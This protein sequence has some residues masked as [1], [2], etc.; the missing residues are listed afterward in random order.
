MILKSVTGVA[1]SEGIH[2]FNLGGSPVLQALLGG[3]HVLHQFV[4]PV[5]PTPGRYGATMKLFTIIGASA[6]VVAVLSAFL[7]CSGEACRGITN[8]LRFLQAS[9]D[10]AGV[11]YQYQDLL[12]D[13]RFVKI[14]TYGVSGFIDGR[15]ECSNYKRAARSLS[16]ADNNTNN[17]QAWENKI[18]AIMIYQEARRHGCNIDH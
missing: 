2:R 9:K 5:S 10:V 16:M 11:R 8:N 1:F 7:L 4:L 18:E 12:S 15:E 3:R 17:G 6:L 13:P 14:D